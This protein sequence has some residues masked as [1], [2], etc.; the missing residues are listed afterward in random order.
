MIK[1]YKLFDMLNRREMKKTDLLDIIAPSTLAKLSKGG[2]IKTDVIDR[3]CD[4][5][6]CQ[7]GDIMEHIKGDEIELF[8]T[9]E[10]TR[11]FYNRYEIYHNEIDIDEFKTLL[12]K[13]TKIVNNEARINQTKLTNDIKRLFDKKIDTV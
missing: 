1:Y 6:N 8:L 9:D 11:E 10:I 3:I 4:F 2:I 13:H 7:P 5:L 12:I